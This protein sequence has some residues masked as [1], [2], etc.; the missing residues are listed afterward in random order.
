MLNTGTG[1]GVGV[2]GLAWGSGP[3]AS[4]DLEIKDAKMVHSD[5]I[6]NDIFEP[7][8]QFWRQ[9]R[10]CTL[11]VFETIVTS[12]NI[13]KSMS[14]KHALWRYLKRFGT[15]ERKNKQRR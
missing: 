5:A 6:W 9:D 4:Y 2:R 12:K 10:A 7:Q 13:L 1:L 14:L 3:A 11:T 15:V 8:R